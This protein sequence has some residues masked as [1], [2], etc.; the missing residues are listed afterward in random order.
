L[1]LKAVF[2]MHANDSPSKMNSFYPNYKFLTRGAVARVQF[3][4]CE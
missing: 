2:I 1:K 4:I 3:R